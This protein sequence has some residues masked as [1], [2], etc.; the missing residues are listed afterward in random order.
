MALS[1]GIV[2]QE[3]IRFSFFFNVYRCFICIIQCPWRLAEDVG[4]PGTN[5]TGG[6]DPPCECWELIPDP[7]KEQPV[8]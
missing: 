6:C 7:L 8:L 4:S 3:D 1:H 2:T 5:V